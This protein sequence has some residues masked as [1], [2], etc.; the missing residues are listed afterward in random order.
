MSSFCGAPEE[1]ITDVWLV[2]VPYKPINPS[3]QALTTQKWMIFLI[4][5]PGLG[6]LISAPVSMVRVMLDAIVENLHNEVEEEKSKDDLADW[7]SRNVGN[8][9]WLTLFWRA[10]RDCPAGTTRDHWY[11]FTDIGWI[12]SLLHDWYGGW[13]GVNQSLRKYRKIPSACHARSFGQLVS[14]PKKVLVST[15]SW[16]QV[17]LAHEWRRTKNEIK[18]RQRLVVTVGVS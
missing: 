13:G 6:E 1:G 17:F 14:M 18:T 15:I 8:Q 9:V 5:A 11:P 10:S 7:P 12:K 3:Y 2:R 16:P 4:Y